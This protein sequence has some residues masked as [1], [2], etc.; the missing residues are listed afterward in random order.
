MAILLKVA[1][2]ATGSL[3]SGIT[4]SDTSLQLKAGEGAKFPSISGSEYFYAVLQ[5]S[6]GAWEVVKV[7]AVSGDQF[8]TIVRNQDSS[9]GSAM[10]FSADDIVSLRPTAQDIEDILTKTQTHEDLTGASAHGLGTI[11]TQAANSV[12]I[13][14]GS[15]ELD[16]ESG[17]RKIKARDHGTAATPEVGNIVYGTGSPPTASNTPIG[18]IFVKYTA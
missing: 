9:T 1:N 7:T 5:T 17:D 10:A 6:A 15:A 11:S 3:N 4:D 14:G 18:T 13:T 12:A 16:N 2:K 8:T